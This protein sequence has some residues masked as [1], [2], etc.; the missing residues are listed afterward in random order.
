[1]ATLINNLRALIEKEQDK[2]EKRTGKRP[3]QADIAGYMGV[4]PST[5]S[6]YIMG[7]RNQWDLNTLTSMVEYFGIPSED[8][9][10]VI[11]ANHALPSDRTK[12]N[13]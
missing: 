7:K 13:S 12:R 1:V 2:L 5:L 4:A 11:P 3:T 9:F 6:A 10:R 8:I